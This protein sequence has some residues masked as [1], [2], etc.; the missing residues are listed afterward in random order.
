MADKRKLAVI[1]ETY[2][3][4]KLNILAME[5]AEKLSETM[6]TRFFNVE[7]YEAKADVLPNATLVLI[8]DPKVVKVAEQIKKDYEKAKVKVEILAMPIQPKAP[9]GKK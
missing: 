7:L 2:W 3:P 4:Q 9:A 6:R 8:P 1:F 5:R